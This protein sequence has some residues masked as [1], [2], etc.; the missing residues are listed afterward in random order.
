MDQSFAQE[1]VSLNY[2]A[3]HLI[4]LVSPLTDF[5]LSVISLALLQGKYMSYHLRCQSPCSD[6]SNINV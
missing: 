3:G 1:P 5:K 2:L 4:A 6:F